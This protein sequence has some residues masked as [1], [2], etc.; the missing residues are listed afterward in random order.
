M[1][2]VI[3]IP[4]RFASTRYPGKPLVELR[5]AGGTSKPLIQRSHEA[6]MRVAGVS[7]V[8]V[9]TEYAKWAEQEGQGSNSPFKGLTDPRVLRQAGL[10]AVWTPEEL[11]AKV[12]EM[13]DRTTFGF[14]PLVGGLSPE[15]G[16]RSLEL[17]EQTMPRLKAAIA[18]RAEEVVPA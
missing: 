16:W 4:A 14:Q 10:F 13:G 5:G 8:H 11:L 17:L 1:K 6:A 9:V 3:L 2:T 12:P 7:A 18:A 15:E